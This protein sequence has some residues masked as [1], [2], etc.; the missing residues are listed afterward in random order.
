VER[1]VEGIAD[2]LHHV[3]PINHVQGISGSLAAGLGI[4]LGAI[5]E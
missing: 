5:T 2:V 3:K 1:R 4:S